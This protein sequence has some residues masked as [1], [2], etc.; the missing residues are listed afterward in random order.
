[1][2]F[3][4]LALVHFQKYWLL[5]VF[6]RGLLG[7]FGWSIFKILLKD[8]FESSLILILSDIVIFESA[9]LI[10]FIVHYS[11]L[12]KKADRGKK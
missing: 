1:M 6:L 5:R 12:K 9:L 4:G 2:I 10:E 11:T 8:P 7:L 3:M